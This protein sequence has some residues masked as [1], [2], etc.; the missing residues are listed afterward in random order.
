VLVSSFQP[1]GSAAAELRA[2]P[3]A[4]P[5]QTQTLEAPLKNPISLPEN[6]STTNT[7]TEK[8]DILSSPKPGTKYATGQ[9]INLA[10]LR[11]KVLD[12]TNN[13]PIRD[14]RAVLSKDGEEQKRYQT[15]SGADGSFIFSNIEPGDYTVTVSANEKLAQSQQVKL[16]TAQNNEVVLKLE[17]LEGADILRITGKRTLIH[18]EN[19]GSETRLD[20]TFINQYKTGNDLRELIESTPG[21]IPDTYGNIITRGEH[22]SINYELDG[23]VLPEAAGVLQQ[24]QFVTP[25]SLE[26]LKVDIGGYQAEDGGGPM[27]AVVHMKS[28]PILPK[29][30]F[31]VGQQLG[32]PMAG[33]F[34]YNG[35]TAFSQDPSSPWY[36]LR[37]ASSG[38]VQGTSMG[39]APPVKDY[40]HNN[41]AVLNSLT[42]LE[43]LLGERD[44]LGLTLGLN[45]SFMQVPTS[46][47]SANAGVSANQHDAQ[48]YLILNYK[49]RFRRFFDEA[50]LHI[51]NAFYYQNYHS[52]NVFDPDPVINGGQPL[53]S[54]APQAL[55]F[56][57]AFSAQ[58][59]ITKVLFKTHHLK[60]GFLSE[61]RPV[62]TDFSGTYYNN[63]P[64]STLAPYGAVISP[65]TQS[66]NGPQFTK[67]MGRLQASRFLQSAY[68]QDSWR[69]QAGILRR[70]TLDTG[71][72]AD[73]YHGVF[74]D[75]LPVAEAIASIPGAT[76]FN[77]QPFMTQRVTDAQASGRFGTSVVLTKTTV[78]RGSF[79]NLFMPPPVDL[80]STPPTVSGPGG[81]LVNGFYNGL[82]ENTYNGTLRPMRATRGNL[83]DTSVEQQVGKRFVARTNLF[84]KT[85]ENYGDSGVIGNSTLY[86][87]QSIDKQEAYG[88]E[89]RFD[90]KPKKD[91]YGLNGFVSNTVSVAYLRGNKQVIGGNYGIQTTPIEAK[92]P[93]HDRRI[94]FDAGLGYKTRFNWWSLFDVQLL[95]GLQ[96]D[97]PVP[98]YL[99][100]ASRTPVLVVLN[101]S[102]GY[103]VPAKLKRKYS[104]LPDNFDVRLQ[105][106]LNNREATNLGSPFQGTRYLLPFRFLVGC[107][108]EIGK[109]TQTSSLPHP[110]AI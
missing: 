21:V 22:N 80:F 94:A 84:Y 52:R 24:S 68:F 64:T 75:T 10:E 33:N 99:P 86:N 78:L 14:A 45:E 29:P 7:P 20:K 46:R 15:E 63:D 36:K 105:N 37:I 11:G 19:I 93:D 6:P 85:L 8:N 74:G 61:Y 103:K 69:P 92:Y 70:V 25:R 3:E 81:G 109:A 2:V 88:V 83:I 62:Y 39:N 59:D 96:N 65:F 82:V 13:Q 60:A 50:N 16:T 57:Y 77:I 107:N 95:S 53:Q 1:A 98:P 44:T 48:D 34:Y 38:A 79:S 30:F 43:Y 40:T 32:A 18:P 56:D 51:L 42:K 12:S 106:L 31:T 26:S 104:F 90:L 66:V 35:S 9:S 17:D 5:N 97:L 100:H 89:N 91:G 58:G 55:R 102:T 49:H 4:L 41:R 87:R 28:L 27:G 110:Q 72:R 101:L 108:W 71:I 73:V 47:I 54:I 76:P 23:V 67:G